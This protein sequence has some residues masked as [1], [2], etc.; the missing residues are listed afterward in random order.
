MSISLLNISLVGFPSIFLNKKKRFNGRMTKKIKIAL[1]GN[2]SSSFVRCDYE[3]LKKYFNVSVVQEPHK[4]L[5][6]LKHFFL[7]AKETKKCDLT[8]SWLAWWHSAFAVFF[9]KLFRKKSIVVI[10]GHGAAYVPELNYG[11]YTTRR[12]RFA[13]NYIYKNADKVLVVESSLKDD[14]INNAKVSG[15]NIDYLPT[16]FNPDYWKFKGKKEKI[17]LTVAGADT[18]KRLKLKGFDTFVQSARYVPEAK[19]V[20]VG[21]KGDA[22]R[23]LES[24]SS[25]N[26]ELIEFLSDKALLQCYQ[27]AQ[28]YCQLSIREGLPTALCEAMLCE[29]VPVGSKINGVKTAIGD[30]GFYVDYGDEKA[31]A[32]KIKEALAS[33]EDLG[34][35]ARERIKKQFPEERRREGL[36][37]LVL[38]M[39]P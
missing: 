20:V 25:K 4:K 36:K 24:I 17:V 33:S 29:C 34:K 15:E 35:K 18:L 13:V 7:V 11:A 27:M 21:V 23:Y 37:K 12:G 6:W 10:G 39:I 30:T 28:V 19:F 16:G 22:K 9:S 14:I 5:E 32:D 38:E 8:F 3:I 2:I 26:V 31:T 1:V